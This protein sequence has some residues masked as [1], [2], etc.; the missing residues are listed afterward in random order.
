M[1]RVGKVGL[2]AHVLAFYDSQ[3]EEMLEATA[4]IKSA[5]RNNETALFVI[6]EDV[7]VDALKTKMAENGIEVD[8]LL[9]TGAL[10]FMRN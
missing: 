9:S 7:D 2:T 6:R 8:R 3:E 4:F 5:I 1:S 10:I